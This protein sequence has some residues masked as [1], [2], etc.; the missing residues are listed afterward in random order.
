MDSD[1]VIVII[2]AMVMVTLRH[3][4]ISTSASTYFARI[5]GIPPD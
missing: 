4:P 2:M 1:T 5:G 3:S